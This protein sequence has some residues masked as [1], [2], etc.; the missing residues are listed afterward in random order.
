MSCN[1]T[2]TDYSFHYIVTYFQELE[3][4]LS[5]TTKIKRISS[6][7][8]GKYIEYAFLSV[9]LFL[10]NT[11]IKTTTKNNNKQ[12]KKNPPQRSS[13]LWVQLFPTFLKKDFVQE[14]S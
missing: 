2:S 1:K 6:K 3:L 11:K 5:Q 9:N 14:I 10:K 12:T 13:L 4:V 7:N 8:G